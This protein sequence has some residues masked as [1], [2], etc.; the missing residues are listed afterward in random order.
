MVL[1]RIDLVCT[2]GGANAFVQAS[3]LL[4]GKKG[5]KIVRMEVTVSLG[6][7]LADAD[8]F[9]VQLTKT[10]QSGILS[11]S[12]NQVV[13]GR[14]ITIAGAPAGAQEPYFL[15]EN[16]PAYTSEGIFVS[17]DSDSRSAADVWTFSIHYQEFKGGY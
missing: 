2:Q 3:K 1:K 5:V 17:V 8:Q 7:A 13:W 16:L 6:G 11:R 10:T 15:I 4:S 14:T 12:S 9:Q